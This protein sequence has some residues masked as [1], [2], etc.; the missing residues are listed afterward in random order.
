MAALDYSDAFD[1]LIRILRRHRLDWIVVQVQEQV[2]TGKPAT[3]DMVKNN[4]P[5]CLSG[6]TAPLP[7]AHEIGNLFLTIS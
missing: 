3:K 1:Q 2:R 4:F 7:H 5:D 6:T